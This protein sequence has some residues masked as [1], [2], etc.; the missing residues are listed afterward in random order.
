MKISGLYGALNDCLYRAHVVD[1]IKY[2]AITDFD[3]IFLILKENKTLLEF[4]QQYDDDSIHS[5]RFQNVFFFT[6]FKHDY[7][8]LPENAGESITQLFKTFK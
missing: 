2:V 8:N 7:S 6:M 4:I 3:E 1:T 5:F